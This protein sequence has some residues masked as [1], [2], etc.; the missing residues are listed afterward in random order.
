MTQPA[1]RDLLVKVPGGLHDQGSCIFDT[2][3]ETIVQFTP[4]QAGEY[5]FAQIMHVGQAFT[6]NPA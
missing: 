3:D 4:R 1:A 2:V 6:A 5:T